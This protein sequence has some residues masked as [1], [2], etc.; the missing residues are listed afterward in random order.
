MAQHRPNA[1]HSARSASC[2]PVPRL[3]LDGADVG[4]L[5]GVAAGPEIGDALRWLEGRSPRIRSS[6]R[7]RR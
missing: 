6:T 1:E 3:A 7:R 4:A 5:I 2:S